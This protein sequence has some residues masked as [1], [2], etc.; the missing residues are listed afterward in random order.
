MNLIIQEIERL[1]ALLVASKSP[2]TGSYSLEHKRKV[3]DTPQ[4]RA[5]LNEQHWI[6]DI[7]ETSD[8]ASQAVLASIFAIKQAE[9]LLVDPDQISGGWNKWHSF[10]ETLKGLEDFYSPMG[11]IIGYQRELLSRLAVQLGLLPSHC[12][13]KVTYAK[14]PRIDIRQET[15]AVKEA[16]SLAIDQWSKMA[17][18]MPVG[19]AGDRL[20]LEDGNAHPL[21][22]AFLPFEG[23]TLLEGLIQDIEAIELLV[24]QV[25]GVRYYTPIALMTSE[26]KDNH[27]RIEQM[28]KDRQYFG[29]PSNCF[30]LFG[31]KRVPVVTEQGNW[32]V[33]TPLEPMLKP[34]GHGV[35]W[36]AAE[37]FGIF[38]WLKNLGCTHALIRQV[39]NP[40]ASTDYNLLALAGF[41]LKTG[42]AL[43]FCSCSR[44]AH[45]SE[46]MN[47]LRRREIDGKS[48]VCVTNVEYTDFVQEGI[49]DEA[50]EP[51][52]P[53]SA[54]SSNT[55]LFV[56]HLE[57]IR[58]VTKQHAFPGLILNLKSKVNVRVG[59]EIS[60]VRLGRLEAMMQNIADYLEIP[61]GGELNQFL[62]FADRLKL[63]SVAKNK[64]PEDG[65]ANETAVS[66]FFDRQMMWRHLLSSRC[67]MHLAMV[68]SPEEYYHKIPPFVVRISPKLGP[69]HAWIS[70]RIRGG[71]LA[72]G[73]YVDFDLCHLA[74][75]DIYVDGGFKIHAKDPNRAYAWIHQVSV[76]NAGWKEIHPNDIWKGDT[77]PSGLLD[78]Q[79]EGAG[80]FIAQQVNFDG[81]QKIVVPD[82][83]AVVANYDE[84]GQL[85]L[86]IQPLDSTSIP[87]V[88]K[89]LSESWHKLFMVN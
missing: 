28:L 62:L 45:A 3:L 33:E 1:D 67:Q 20:G 80:L 16:V 51:G 31:Q 18:I 13:E 88:F 11:G 72:R 42:K 5:Y 26:E 85:G 57:S 55:N 79:F 35:I 29:R 53:Y 40:M 52:S 4:L 81:E 68:S 73:A 25:T 15:A 38:D 21:P 48:L 54:F 59:H 41:A 49:E 14:P 63:I 50:E 37:V 6:A 36:R 44:L 61:E 87:P 58:A 89:D 22:A 75:Q 10:I 24:Q 2:D 12:L 76:V 60:N 39:N 30:R 46:G 47:V 9:A 66:A 71:T 78:I 17:F 69:L 7:Y 32:A 74:M 23:R 70:K 86:K 64:S 82:G 34:G 19:G 77:I 65:Y 27:Q 43:G 83:M 56:V 8:P 84:Y